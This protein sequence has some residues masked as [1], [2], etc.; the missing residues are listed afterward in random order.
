MDHFINSKPNEIS[1]DTL[2]LFRGVFALTG[3]NG[4]Q[5]IIHVSV[6][7]NKSPEMVVTYVML[8]SLFVFDRQCCT[9]G[10]LEDTGDGDYGRRM[11]YVSF[12]FQITTDRF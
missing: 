3:Y 12:N 10:P 9:C 5:G 4:L 1:R 6:I 11:P 7:D 8:P 2:F